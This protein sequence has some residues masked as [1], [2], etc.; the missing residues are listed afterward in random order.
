MQVE[1]NRQGLAGVCLARPRPV[2]HTA[3]M[4]ERD[5]YEDN[6]LSPPLQWSRAW[7]AILGL[8]VAVIAFIV[9]VLLFVL[10]YDM[11]R[12]R[13]PVISITDARNALVQT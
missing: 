2:G 13:T 4:S 3:A 6:D 12:K 5:D 10:A 7:S 8:V 1:A 9:L 11:H